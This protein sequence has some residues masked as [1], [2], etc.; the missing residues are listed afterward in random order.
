MLS[1]NPESVNVLWEAYEQ[2]LNSLEKEL[3]SHQIEILM[4]KSKGFQ[5]NVPESTIKRVQSYEDTIFDILYELYTYFKET[6][7]DGFEKLVFVPE[8]LRDLAEGEDFLPVINEYISSGRHKAI[9]WFDL[10]EAP[11]CEKFVQVLKQRDFSS[12]TLEINKNNLGHRIATIRKNLD[13]IKVALGKF[14]YEVHSNR[15]FEKLLQDAYAKQ[16]PN[17]NPVKYKPGKP[18]PD[19]LYK[20]TYFLCSV[21]AQ[22]ENELAKMIESQK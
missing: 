14:V 20:N 6:K 18:L 9:H 8:T 5:M 7:I 12:L 3:L 2:E 1:R 4:I 19:Y 17:S 21:F 15:M 13:R 10:E 11:Q 22:S 16:D